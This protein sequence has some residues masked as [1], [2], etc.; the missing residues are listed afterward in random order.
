MRQFLT[1]LIVPALRVTGFRFSKHYRWEST[2]FHAAV[3]ARVD[4]VQANIRAG[5][6]Y[7]VPGRYFTS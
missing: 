5:M 1:D 4:T 7:D 3:Y 6:R 2:R